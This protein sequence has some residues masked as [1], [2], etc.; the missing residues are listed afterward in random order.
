MCQ[1]RDVGVVWRMVGVSSE[2][3]NNSGGRGRVYARRDAAL[4]GGLDAVAAIICGR[5]VGRSG[6][7]DPVGA[8]S[9]ATRQAGAVA[10]TGAAHPAGLSHWSSE[11]PALIRGR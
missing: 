1:R 5:R 8:I 3:L 4:G 11:A 7:P 10:A 9:A 6:A 2:T